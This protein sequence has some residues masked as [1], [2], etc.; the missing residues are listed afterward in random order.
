MSWATALLGV[1]ERVSSAGADAVAA[2][3]NTGMLPELT[4]ATLGL[5]TGAFALNV[6]VAML[7]LNTG[8][9]ALGVAALGLNTGA[10]VLN[11]R[12]AALGLKFEFV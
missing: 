6:R 3:V 4:E 12:V 2:G 8:A 10:S 9:S 11:V 7:G 1:A 5:K